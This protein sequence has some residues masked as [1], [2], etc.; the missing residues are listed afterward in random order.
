MW[1]VGCNDS[2]IIS[3]KV[4]GGSGVEEALTDIFKSVRVVDGLV[5]FRDFRRIMP[6]YQC[7]ATEE[8]ESQCTGFLAGQDGRCCYVVNTSGLKTCGLGATHGW[9]R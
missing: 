5:H 8:E 6:V 2:E 1:Y 4:E 3:G 9:Q 7:T